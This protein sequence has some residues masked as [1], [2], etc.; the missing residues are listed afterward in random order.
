MSKGQETATLLNE[1]VAL[2]L[3]Q[4]RMIRGFSQEELAS[5]SGIDRTFMSAVERGRRNIT[6]STL[7]RILGPLDSSYCEFLKLLNQNIQERLHLTQSA[8][9]PIHSSSS[10]SR[11][12]LTPQFI[13]GLIHEIGSPASVLDTTLR[14]RNKD[15][16]PHLSP[17]ELESLRLSAQRI[18]QLVNSMGTLI[19][20]PLEKIPYSLE[21]K[22]LFKMGLE[23]MNNKTKYPIKFTYL[24]SNGSNQITYITRVKQ[25]LIFDLMRTLQDQLTFL[26][27]CASGTKISWSLQPGVNHW[28]ITLTCP[29]IQP[30]QWPSKA[31]SNYYF[32]SLDG[33]LRFSPVFYTLTHYQYSIRYSENRCELKLPT[34]SSLTATH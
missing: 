23:S 16:A 7:N 21:L 32:I 17:K 10:S 13:E 24:K 8:S 19:N 18:K 11:I 9:P 20:E 6:L 12:H 2:T 5:Q 30:E 4:L 27:N 15:D 1:T 25:Q 14:E 31:L 29:D 26:A 34:W 28:T 3:K 22:Q 33:A